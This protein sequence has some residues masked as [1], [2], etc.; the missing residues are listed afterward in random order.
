MRLLFLRLHLLQ[1]ATQLSSRLVLEYAKGTKW[2]NSIAASTREQLQYTHRPVCSI[3]KRRLVRS[4]HTPRPFAFIYNNYITMHRHADF[5]VAALTTF[6]HPSRV[7]LPQRKGNMKD[8][9]ELLILS[10]WTAFVCWIG[11]GIGY[12]YGQSDADE[13]YARLLDE[14]R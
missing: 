7:E 4:E 8:I 3:I 13:Q 11:Y 9:L 5:Q 1:E 14:R 2:S 12:E 10:G 6:C